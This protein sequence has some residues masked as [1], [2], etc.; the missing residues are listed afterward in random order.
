A[1]TPIEEALAAIWAEVLG[2]DEVDVADNFFDL[3]GHSLLAIQLMAHIEN[4]FG[5]KLPVTTLFAAPTVERLAGG[6]PRGAAPSRS[7]PLVRL[8]P[9]GAGRNLFLIH[10]MGGDV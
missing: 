4:V 3:G 9:G 5:V 6:V 2:L 8:H 1:Q 10:P 7:S